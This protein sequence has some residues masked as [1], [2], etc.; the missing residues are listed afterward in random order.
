MNSLQSVLDEVV[1]VL[2]PDVNEV[3]SSH[4][5][6]F[7]GS[8]I[9]PDVIGIEKVAVTIEQNPSFLTFWSW[10]FRQ[11]E[12]FVL[13]WREFALKIWITG[14][15]GVVGDAWATAS[16]DKATAKVFMVKDQ[17]TM[18][19]IDQAVFYKKTVATFFER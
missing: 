14:D 19:W 11:L 17:L 3:W 5:T 8:L 1:L 4:C 15:F 18:V 13:E 9:I 12:L 7:N 2:V 6:G 16:R 10:S